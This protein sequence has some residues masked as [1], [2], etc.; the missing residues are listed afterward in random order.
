MMLDPVTIIA[1]VAICFA[2]G[3]WN[4]VRSAAG[5]RKG[6][7]RQSEPWWWRTATLKRIAWLLLLTIWAAVAIKY[8]GR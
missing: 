3:I 4:G 6:P 1:A 7:M 5:W 2:A 8:C